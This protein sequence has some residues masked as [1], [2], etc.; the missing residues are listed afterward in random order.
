MMF[1]ESLQLRHDVPM[2]ATRRKRLRAA[3]IEEIK[4]AALAQL[5]SAG[6]GGLSIRGIAR[7]IGM[8]PAGIYRYYDGLDALLTELIAD[9]YGDLADHVQAAGR[10]GESPRVRLSN[11]IVGYRAWCLDHPNRFLLIFGTPIPGYVAPEDGPTVVANRRLG[12]AFFALGA[13]AWQRGELTSID[14]NRPVQPAEQAFADAVTAGFP[15][16]YVGAFLSAWAHFHGIVSLEI[17]NQLD[18]VYDD[19][20]AFYREEVEHM[21]DRL[22]R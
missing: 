2:T 16:E 20:D 9:A 5:A 3:T 18:W 10:R 21:L 17:L 7:A 22:F 19:T 8:S 13:E 11:A 4:Q 15:P 6:V 1:A 14:R 12:E